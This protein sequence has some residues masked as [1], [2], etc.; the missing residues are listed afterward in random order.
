LAHTTHTVEE[1]TPF[2]TENVKKKKPRRERQGF[3]LYSL[4][5]V[6]SKLISWLPERG[7]SWCAY[8]LTWLSFSFLRLRR[9]LVLKNIERAFPEWSEEQCRVLGFKSTYNFVLS[10][11][12]FLGA[13]D[14]KL[15]DHVHI[16]QKRNL[17]EALKAGRGAYILCFHMGNWEAMGGAI[18]RQIARAH[19]VVK[20]VGPPKV[21]EF[22]TKLRQTN[23]FYSIGRKAKG[24]GYRGIQQALARNEV[25]G[26]VMDQARP[27]SP[28]MLFFNHPAKTNTSFAHI[29]QRRPAPVLPAYIIRT[30]LNSH[31]IIIAPPLPLTRD[32]ADADQQALA[33]TEQFSRIIEEVI[34]KHP[35]Q[36][37]W[38]HDRWK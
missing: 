7:K 21:D 31:R 15:A 8:G 9:K 4:L 25:V 38:Y 26:F 6:L 24:D 34:R 19:V 36:Y 11:L 14:G 17:V 1:T 2:V 3:L 28:R 29:W 13:R 27:D 5:N 32:I 10:I 30:G 20:K 23:Q 33:H 12:Q 37:F 22:I 18:S 16:E 35:E